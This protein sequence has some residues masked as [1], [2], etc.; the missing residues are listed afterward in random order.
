MVALCSQC[1]AVWLI[2]WIPFWEHIG[3]LYSTGYS[4]KCQLQGVYVY[5]NAYAQIE[6]VCICINTLPLPDHLTKSIL[7]THHHPHSI[8]VQLKLAKKNKKNKKKC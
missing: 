3:L 6:M 4:A 1:F 8:H 7:I 5:L 2:I